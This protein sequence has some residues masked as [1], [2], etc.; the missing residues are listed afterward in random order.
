MCKPAILGGFE[1]GVLPAYSFLIEHPP[2]GRKLVFD[3]GTRKDWENMAPF[4]VKWLEK[5]DCKVSV[6]KDVYDILEENGGKPDGVEAVFWSV[7][8]SSFDD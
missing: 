2:S 6:E 1:I 7:S 5:Q 3:L 4:I 8:D